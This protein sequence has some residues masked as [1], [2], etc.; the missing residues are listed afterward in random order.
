[1]ILDDGVHGPYTR[2]GQGADHAMNAMWTSHYRQWGA[3]GVSKQATKP[4]DC[5]CGCK[6]G[7]AHSV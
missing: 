6:C 1:M 4:D 2:G 7:E 3:I 5:A